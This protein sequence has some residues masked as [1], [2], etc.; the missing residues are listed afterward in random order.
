MPD[1]NAVPEERTVSDETSEETARRVL[2]P[3]EAA[4]AS[5]R[6]EYDK[7][8]TLVA[9]LRA[10]I[11]RLRRGEKVRAVGVRPIGTINAKNAF[12]P[13]IALVGGL[14]VDDFPDGT[15]IYV[16]VAVLAA[17]DTEKGSAQ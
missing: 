11:D 12:G 13:S 17:L 15:T 3:A 1:P 16:E 10:E 14:D 9:E 7:Q 6:A 2:N 5:L 8:V 4:A